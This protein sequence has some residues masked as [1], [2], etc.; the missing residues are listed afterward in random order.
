ML[1]NKIEASTTVVQIFA[2]HTG[3]ATARDTS[4]NTAGNSTNTAGNLDPDLFL[5]K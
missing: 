3:G 2:A 1:R 5:A 4:T